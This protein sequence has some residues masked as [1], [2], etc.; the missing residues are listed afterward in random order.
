M[1][2]TSLDPWPL[3]KSK[4]SDQTQVLAASGLPSPRLSKRR[5][6][7]APADRA[8]EDPA[9]TADAV[10]SQDHALPEREAIGEARVHREP[11]ASKPMTVETPRDRRCRGLACPHQP[12]TSRRLCDP[13]M[14]AQPTTFSLDTGCPAPPRSP[15]L[16]LPKPVRSG[17]WM[18]P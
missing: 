1:T 13:D 7:A 16:F 17:G 18:A 3:G 14:A 10:L 2:K 9:P 11:G 6:D 15:G 12:L 5:D 4:A 8:L